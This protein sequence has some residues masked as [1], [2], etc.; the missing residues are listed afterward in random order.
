MK[1]LE[2]CYYSIARNFWRQ[3]GSFIAFID[4]CIVPSVKDYNLCV[5]EMT[6]AISQ[7][8]Q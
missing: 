8:T 7:K 2:M 3:I 1:S 6:E 5:Q 4:C